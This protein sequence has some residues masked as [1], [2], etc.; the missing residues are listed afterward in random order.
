MGV[1]EWKAR[2]E[3][4][5]AAGTL[6]GAVGTPTPAPKVAA[7]FNLETLTACSLRGEATGNSHRCPSCGGRNVQVKE[8]V[9]SV[10]GV[11]TVARLVSGVACCRICEDR[12]T[13]PITS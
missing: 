3:A 9:C 6:P 4:R 7:R 8:F 12:V 13:S 10:H 5:R 2:T 1:K 11:C